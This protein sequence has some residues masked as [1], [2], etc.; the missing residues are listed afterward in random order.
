[1]PCNQNGRYR[2]AIELTKLTALGLFFLLAISAFVILGE[3][4]KMN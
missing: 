1:M 3:I 4:A 2:K